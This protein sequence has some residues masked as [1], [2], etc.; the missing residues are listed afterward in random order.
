MRENFKDV[1]RDRARLGG[2]WAIAGVLFTSK[3]RQ[4]ARSELGED[5]EIVMLEMT[6]EEQEERIRIRHEGSQD[7]VDLM[8][9]FADQFEPVGESEVFTR[10]RCC[11]NPRGHTMARRA[12][13]GQRWLHRSPRSH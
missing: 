12:L 2:D 10:R 6:G 13:Q 5:L 9:V 1:A 8:K 11:E 7:A 4:M 3:M